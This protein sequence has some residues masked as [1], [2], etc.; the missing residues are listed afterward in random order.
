MTPDAG[1]G[2]YTLAGEI[3]VG[4]PAAQI[5][6]WL[7]E[8]DRLE[9]WMLGVDAA[10]QMEDDATQLRVITSSGV[11]AGWTFMGTTVVESPTRVVRT[12]ALEG[13]RTGVIAHEVDPTGYHRE[14]RYDLYA[15]DGGATR[16]TCSVATTIPGLAAVAARAGA[17]A[18]QKTLDRSLER[19]ELLVVGR[20]RGLFSMLRG[21][22]LPPA[23]F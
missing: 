9:Q 16:L 15:V 5:V 2:G 21:S 4:A 3:T 10:V 11:Y 13:L 20:P 6:P 1:P 22:R 18:E 7:T 8:A 19:L 14:V 17:K 12:Y 23:A